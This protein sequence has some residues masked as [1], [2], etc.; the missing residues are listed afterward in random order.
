MSVLKEVRYIVGRARRGE[1]RVV[2]L[3]RLLLL[4]TPNGD[5]W[6]LDTDD[7]LALCLALDGQEQPYRIV[8]SSG[9]FAIDWPA[10]FAIEGDRFVVRDRSGTTHRITGYPLAEIRAA[11]DRVRN[12]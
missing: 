10:A 8:E 9:K 6:L 11:I 12:S 7:D 5:A 4:S 2:T 3:D 1:G